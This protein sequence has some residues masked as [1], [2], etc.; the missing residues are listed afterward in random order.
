MTDLE[1][2]ILDELYFIKSFDDL[3]ASLDIEDEIL[4]RMLKTMMIK[5]W[6]RSYIT[7]SEELPVGEA[8]MDTDCRHY[9]YIASKSGLLSHN[10]DV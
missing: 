9:L 3:I 6:V 1:Y 7:P 5:G 2:D 4:K 8:N 10:L